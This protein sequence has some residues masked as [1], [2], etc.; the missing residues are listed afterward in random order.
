VSISSTTNGFVIIV[1]DCVVIGT[2]LSR[3]LYKYDTEIISTDQFN[4][5]KQQP[6]NIR[7]QV[8][9]TPPSDYENI[10]NYHSGL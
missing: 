6:R 1:R 4:Q 2:F 3:S 5:Q 8:T 7:R 9:S 10:A